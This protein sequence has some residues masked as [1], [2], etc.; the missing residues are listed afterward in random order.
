M[1]TVSASWLVSN[2]GSRILARTRSG[3]VAY[4]RPYISNSFLHVYDLLSERFEILRIG[5]LE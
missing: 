3:S 2:M 5:T 4:F 1:G